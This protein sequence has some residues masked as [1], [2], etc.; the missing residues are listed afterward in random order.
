M[1]TDRNGVGGIA[2]GTAVA[3]L[4][5]IALLVG[6]FLDWYSPG[7]FGDGQGASAWTVFEFV[8]LL[9]AVLAVTVLIAV[10]SSLAPRAYLA[11][12][13]P[14]TVAVAG[15]AALV[16][17]VNAL[18]DDPPAARGAALEEGIWIAF[19]GAL[20]IVIGAI[21][22]RSRIR[23]V[24]TPRED[25]PPDTDELDVIEDDDEPFEPDHDDETREY[26]GR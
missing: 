20:L 1:D 17:V 12:I 4:G 18:L 13:P 15:I 5:A 21:L 19:G 7:G 23:L 22:E 2:A 26:P 6:L 10:A 3:A 25:R 24:V 11:A 9:L 14:A 8:D 16:L